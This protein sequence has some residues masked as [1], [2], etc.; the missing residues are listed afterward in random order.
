MRRRA[1]G[2]LAR[3]CELWS[4]AP[5]APRAR[6]SS[7]LDVVRNVRQQEARP[8][9]RAGCRSGS[10]QERLPR[11]AA[12]LERGDHPGAHERRLS[13]P[14]RRHDGHERLLMEKPRHDHRHGTPP[15]EEPPRVGGLEGGEARVRVSLLVGR[16]GR[17]GRCGQSALEFLGAQ[18][19][20][21]AYSILDPLEQASIDDGAGACQ[22]HG[23][24]L[25]P[26][27]PAWGRRGAGR[28]PL[29]TSDSG[30]RAG[31]PSTSSAS[32]R[33]AAHRFVGAVIDAV[34][35]RIFAPGDMYCFVPTGA[36]VLGPG[37]LDDL[38]LGGRRKRATC[39]A[40]PKSSTFTMPVSVKKMFEGLR[41]RWTTPRSCAQV[42]ARR[43][44]DDRDHEPPRPGRAAAPAVALASTRAAR[45]G[46]RHYWLGVVRRALPPSS[47][48]ICSKVL[49]QEVL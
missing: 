2:A 5:R 28:S 43:A 22:G 46:R 19:E 15:P 47:S 40:R 26:G 27:F 24:Q 4:Q 20:G 16:R 45:P 12:A 44:A 36:L 37:V 18:L 9:P 3:R 8:A 7:R 34:S 48:S 25:A 35:V 33:P 6:W 31:R 11:L 29:A 1:P 17:A 23:T 10:E 14:R 38:R 49:P 30:V 32:T 13:R 42:L 21:A 41:S 39:W